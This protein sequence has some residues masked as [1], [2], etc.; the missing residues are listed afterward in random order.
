VGWKLLGYPRRKF[1][2]HHQETPRSHIIQSSRISLD[3]T[4]PVGI[5]SW[6]FLH[7]FMSPF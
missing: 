6:G 2:R 3:N 1:H 5:P 7:S 4:L